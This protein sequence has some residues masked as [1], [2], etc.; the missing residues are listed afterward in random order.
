[1]NYRLY[2]LGRKARHIR[3]TEPF[4]AEDDVHA[5]GIAES[6]FSFCS[7]DFDGYEVWNGMTMIADD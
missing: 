1:M 3:S 2:L 6:V 7:D 5:V 4:G